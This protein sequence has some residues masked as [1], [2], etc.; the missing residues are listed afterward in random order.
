[1]ILSIGEIIIILIL[2]CIT[3]FAFF[4]GNFWYEYY[5]LASNI[6]STYLTQN[7]F[8]CKHWFENKFKCRNRH[9]VKTI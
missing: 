2:N 7:Y 1:M 3:N 5:N 4:E 8:F 6:I 9:C